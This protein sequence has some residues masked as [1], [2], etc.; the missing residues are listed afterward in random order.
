[1][2]PVYVLPYPVCRSKAQVLMDAAE[3]DWVGKEIYL[4]MSGLGAAYISSR[5]FDV[6]NLHT[7]NLENNKLKKLSDQISYLTK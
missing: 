4:D 1:M 5:L 2:N 6:S 7:L 3:D